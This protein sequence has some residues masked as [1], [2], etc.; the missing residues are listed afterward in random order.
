MRVRFRSAN[1]KWFI[2]LSIVDE[3]HTKVNDA[4]VV[5]DAL[6]TDIEH[7]VPW[8]DVSMN[9]PLTMYFREIREK[10]SHDVW[11]G[12]QRDIVKNIR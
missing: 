6:G 2:L 5:G 7:D 9:E 3:G 1:G 10:I 4:C 11:Y 8:F 12:K